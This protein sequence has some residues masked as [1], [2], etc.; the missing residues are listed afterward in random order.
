MCVL[1]MVHWYIEKSEGLKPLN[2]AIEEWPNCMLP[3]CLY[4]P[5]DKKREKSASP[6]IQSTSPVQ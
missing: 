6:V 4:I 3:K 2:D 1:V 5:I